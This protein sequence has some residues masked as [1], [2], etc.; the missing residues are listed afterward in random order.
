VEAVEKINK[1]L[2]KKIGLPIIC[3]PEALMA[4]IKE[5]DYSE[6]EKLELFKNTCIKQTAQKKQ[7]VTREYDVEC[8]AELFNY[9]K[10]NSVAPEVVKLLKQT[11]DMLSAAKKQNGYKFLSGLPPTE[12][13]RGLAWQSDFIPICDVDWK[14]IIDN[15]ESRK[16]SL[17]RYYPLFMVRCESYS[18]T[19]NIIRSLLINDD[20]YEFCK[21]QG[22]VS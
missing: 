10:G 21:E 22:F 14:H 9:K 2:K 19:S 7:A 12:Q 17:E 16:D 6:K 11:F 15:F 13:I 18:S 4:L 8:T 1:H 20:L 3:R 5:T